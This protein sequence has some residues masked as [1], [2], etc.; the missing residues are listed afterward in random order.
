MVDIHTNL[1]KHRQ[2]LSEKD[3]LHEREAL[4]WSVMG[5]I[6][7][8]VIVVSLAVWDLILSRQLSAIQA[9]VTGLNGQM[10]GL[11]TASAQQIYLKSRLKL[12]TG[13]LNDRSLVREALQRIFSTNIQ[14]THISGVSFLTPIV[15]NL[16]VQADSVTSLKS[17][18]DYYEADSG[19]FTQV[20]SRGLSRS[21][22]G[23]Y[24]LS[25]ELTLPTGTT[26]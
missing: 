20:V 7:V 8:V 23:S 10:Q 16:Q 19:Y 3:Y 18:V 11:V 26:K 14:G 15:M 1:L 4:R 21:K 2:T 12:V 17:V 24:Q 22:D 5:M 25:L 6:V 13:F 9:E